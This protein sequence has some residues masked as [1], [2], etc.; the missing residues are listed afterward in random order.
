MPRPIAVRANGADA[1]QA[2]VGEQVE[3]LRQLTV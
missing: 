1:D 3:K 2:K